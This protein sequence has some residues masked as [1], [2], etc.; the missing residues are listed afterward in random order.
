LFSQTLETYLATYLVAPNVG[1]SP[2]FGQAIIDLMKKLVIPL[3][4]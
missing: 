4:N 1:E 2:L 3:E